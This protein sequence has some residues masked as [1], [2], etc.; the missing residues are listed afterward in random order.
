MDIG[1]NN[2]TLKINDVVSSPLSKEIRWNNMEVSANEALMIRGQSTNIIK[3][4]YSSGRSISKRKSKARSMLHVQSMRRC[5]ECQKH[6]HYK[7]YCK[8]KGIEIN[9]VSKEIESTEN[10]EVQEERGDLY[11]ASRST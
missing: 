5:W 6:R 3:G 2:A 9:K 8:S 11:L 7:R 10:K 1:N 4:K